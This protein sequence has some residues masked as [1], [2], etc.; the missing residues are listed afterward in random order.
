MHTGAMGVSN[1]KSLAWLMPK[2]DENLWLV[3]IGELHTKM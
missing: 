3:V 1:F 2:S